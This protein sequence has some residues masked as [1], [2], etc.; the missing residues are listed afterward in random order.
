M[1]EVGV[2]EDE[3]TK[4]SPKKNKKKKGKSAAADVI[5]VKEV[6][7]PVADALVAKAEEKDPIQ[8][9]LED[10]AADDDSL[11]VKVTAANKPASHDVQ[12]DPQDL[13]NTA[14][15]PKKKKKSKDSRER[16]PV[17][18][19]NSLFYFMLGFGLCDPCPLSTPSSSMN[20]LPQFF[21]QSYNLVFHLFCYFQ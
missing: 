17:C 8:A 15:S 4:P 2:T 11:P 3:K 20:Y 9:A 16:Y 21:I 10:A 6:E 19:L 12:E 7:V 5:P 1:E 13:K 14:R 18:S